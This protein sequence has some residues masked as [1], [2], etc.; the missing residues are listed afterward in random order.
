MAKSVNMILERKYYTVKIKLD[1]P[2]CVSSGDDMNTDADVLRNG[3]GEVFVPGSSLAGAFR[4]YSG[5]TDTGEGA[6]GFSNDEN[7]RMSAIFVS[8]M[9][10]EGYPIV[11]VRD[12]V[13]LNDGKTVDNKFDMEIIETGAVGTF[14]L[15]TVRR[16]KDTYDVDQ[17]VSKLLKGLNDGEIRLGA[18]K[19]RG[20]GKCK[21]ISVGNREFSSNDLNEWTAFVPERKNVERYVPIKDKKLEEFMNKSDKKADFIKVRVPLRLKGGISIRRYS[22]Q[23]GKADYEQIT[24]NAKPVIPGSS[25]NGAIRADI[26]HILKSLGCSQ[27][28]ISEVIWTWFGWTEEDIKDKAFEQWKENNVKRLHIDKEKLAAEQSLIVLGESVISGGEFVPVT[29]NKVSRFS[30]AVIKGALYSEVSCFGGETWFEY[31]IRKDSSRDYLALAVIMEMVV[32]D[33]QEGMLP[34]GGL[35]SVGRGIFEADPDKTVYRSETITMEEAQNAL[36][37]LVVSEAV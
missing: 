24:C 23:P 34:V 19:N 18:N 4:D 36:Y 17:E 16:E 29:R 30:A 10:F 12:G 13:R 15:E 1:S 3:T 14:F 35:V 6:Y 7:G 2:L 11:S 32:Q 21:I 26:R 33:I 9:Y 28:K 31:M 27:K 8:D 37:Q 20:F 22:S 25:W 5:V